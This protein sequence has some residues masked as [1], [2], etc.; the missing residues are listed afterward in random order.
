MESLHCIIKT[1]TE[2]TG[3]YECESWT[4]GALKNKELGLKYS[5]TEKC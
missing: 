2:N 3:L 4:V 5:V 1:Y